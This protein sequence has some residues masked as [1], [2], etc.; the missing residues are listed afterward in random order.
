MT[1]VNKGSNPAIGNVVYHPMLWSATT[2]PASGPDI[3]V[4][5]TRGIVAERIRSKYASVEDVALAGSTAA[6]HL[7]RNASRSETISV[8]LDVTDTSHKYL[9][10]DPSSS[11]TLR[12]AR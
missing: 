11:G 6:I 10:K 12:G 3:I 4:I 5:N 7:V 2:L 8:S 1:C 9:P